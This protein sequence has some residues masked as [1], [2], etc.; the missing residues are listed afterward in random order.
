MLHLGA[1][2][3]ATSGLLRDLGAEEGAKDGPGAK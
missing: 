1:T 3:D 2:G